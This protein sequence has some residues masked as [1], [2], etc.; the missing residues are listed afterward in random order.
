MRDFTEPQSVIGIKAITSATSVA[1]SWVALTGQKITAYQVELK[2]VSNTR[3]TVEDTSTT[4][5]NLVPRKS[6]TV[7][8]SPMSGSVL[9]DPAEGIFTTS[10][11][12]YP[13]VLML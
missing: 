5:A 8:V 3:K 12:S 1:V 13:F 7:V 10:N 4:F 9:G 11:F 2:G 6:Y